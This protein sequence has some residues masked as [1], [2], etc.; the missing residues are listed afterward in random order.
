[1]TENNLADNMKSAWAARWQRAA[2]E[3]SAVLAAPLLFK[4]ERQERLVRDH[5]RARAELDR[6]SA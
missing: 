3:I 5:Q 4:P 6:W 2:T 1:M